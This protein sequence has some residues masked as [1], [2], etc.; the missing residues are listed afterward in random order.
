MHW[1]RSQN[2]H[3]RILQSADWSSF[4]PF[5]FAL[6]KPSMF[7]I[8]R[9]FQCFNHVF[10]S[11]MLVSQNRGTPFSHPF[12]DWDFPRNPPQVYPHG[13]LETA[14]GPFRLP[15]PP[16]IPDVSSRSAERAPTLAPLC[17]SSSMTCPAGPWHGL[18]STH[19]RFFMVKP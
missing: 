14:H 7:T 17:S 13:E 11:H 18:G 12:L 4:N 10:I 8:F 19:G 15:P 5:F 3:Q 1:S 9:H 6:V 2:I 16:G